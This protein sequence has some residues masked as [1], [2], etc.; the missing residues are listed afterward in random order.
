M[1]IKELINLGV[2]AAELFLKMEDL[3][4][5]VLIVKVGQNEP[6]DSSSQRN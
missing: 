1:N 3:D 6:L 5:K 2:D 4:K